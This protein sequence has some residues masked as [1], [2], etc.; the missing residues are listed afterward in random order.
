MTF[1]AVKSLIEKNLLESYKNEKE[2]K[3][4]LREFKHNVNLKTISLGEIKNIT[5]NTQRT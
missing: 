2:F 4:T 3:K 5:K 1:G